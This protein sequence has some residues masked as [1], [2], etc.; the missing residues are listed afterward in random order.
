[1]RQ[2]TCSLWWQVLKEYKKIDIT[3]LSSETYICCHIGNSPSV[4]TVRYFCSFGEPS[5]FAAIDI[6]SLHNHPLT[7]CQFS[8]LYVEYIQ[9]NNKYLCIVFCS[10]Q[11]DLRMRFD[12][13]FPYDSDTS[14][15]FPACVCFIWESVDLTMRLQHYLVGVVLRLIRDKLLFLIKLLM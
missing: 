11:L 5:N 6:P 4:E 13:N 9:N 7:N 8:Q 1:M 14:R 15:L 2:V 12:S 3:Y 10:C